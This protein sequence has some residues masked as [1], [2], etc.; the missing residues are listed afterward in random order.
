MA[1]TR[2]CRRADAELGTRL[3][4]ALTA[5][6][7]R[8]RYGQCHSHGASALLAGG[9]LGELVRRMACALVDLASDRGQRRPDSAGPARTAAQQESGEALRR[10]R[11][12]RFDG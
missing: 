5:I 8:Y 1:A 12:L 3:R 10:A 7:A 9:R 4:R 11:A 6:T 2:A